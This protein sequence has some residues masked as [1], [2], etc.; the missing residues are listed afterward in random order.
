MKDMLNPDPVDS[1]AAHRAVCE[2]LG[3]PESFTEHDEDE[4]HPLYD[5][6]YRLFGVEMQRRGYE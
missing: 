4:E 3:L 6:Y 2:Q 5:E 1:G